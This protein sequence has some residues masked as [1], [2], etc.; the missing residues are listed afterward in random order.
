MKIVTWGAGNKKQVRIPECRKALAV[1]PSVDDMLMDVV[2]ELPDV[3]VHLAQ[4][5]AAIR[6]AFPKNI[7]NHIDRA[8]RDAKQYFLSVG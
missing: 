8:G 1:K 5:D 4:F 3:T 2:Y 7:N 6:R